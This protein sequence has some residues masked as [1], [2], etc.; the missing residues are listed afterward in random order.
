[1]VFLFS[2]GLLSVHC[3]EQRGNPQMSNADFRSSR[4][5]SGGNMEG[6]DVRFGITCSTLTAVVT[7]NTAT[8]S[9]NS[10]HDS[11]SSLGGM[12][13]LMNMLLASFCR[14]TR[15]LLIEQ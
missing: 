5:Q 10:M 3:F 13:L 12:V 4:V 14:E 7:S 15:K 2:C 1:M 8:G 6:K 11:F 9:Y